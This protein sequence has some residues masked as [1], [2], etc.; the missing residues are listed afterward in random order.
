MRDMHFAGTVMR[1]GFNLNKGAPHVEGVP[2]VREQL[3]MCIF[4][5]RY[6]CRINGKDDRR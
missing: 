5:S 6:K 2:K 4:S 3:T 1:A